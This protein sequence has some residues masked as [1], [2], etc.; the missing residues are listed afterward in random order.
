MEIQ[1]AHILVP[2][3]NIPEKIE[4]NFL[5]PQRKKNI[6]KTNLKIV[7]L[8]GGLP[9]NGSMY[10]KKIKTD[11]INRVDVQKPNGRIIP[12]VDHCTL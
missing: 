3:K 12:I 7:I 1:E 5:V 10:A 2:K 6:L 8:V 9:K 11:H 4:E